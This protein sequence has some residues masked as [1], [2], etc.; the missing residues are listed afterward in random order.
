MTNCAFVMEQT[1]GHVTHHQNL[2]RWADQDASIRAVWLPV[3]ESEVDG[4]D[5]VPGIRSNWSLRGSLRAWTCL[6][7]AAKTQRL[8]AIFFHTQTVSLFALNWMARVPTVIS[9]DATPKNFDSF[10]PEYGH[11]AG[12]DSWLDRR[13]FR[14][15]QRTFESCAALTCMSDWAKRSLVEDYGIPPAKVTVIQP[16]VDLE[17]WNFAGERQGRQ[18]GRPLRLLFVGADFV[19]KGGPELVEA[20]RNG[21]QGTCQLDIVTKDAQAAQTLQGIEGLHVHLGLSPNSDPLRRLYANADLFVFPTHGECL[22][23]AAIE[24][25][26]AGL[27]VIATSVGGVPEVV[28]DGLNGLMIPLN[29]PS[30][31]G[32]AVRAL[33]ADPTRLENMACASREL[34]ER[35]FD[36]SRNYT[37]ILSLL[38]RVTEEHEG[39]K[40]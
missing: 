22:G 34:A 7:A 21:L 20:F 24:A 26:A 16:G 6:N 28:E 12:N 15:N 13:K 30:S 32:S 27:P 37:A 14:W 36:G 4:W 8:D 39:A 23:I 10:G 33:L 19:R 38:K 31:I 25:M 1:L 17:L 5:R 29:D 11:R 9:L 35:R 40:Q 18:D 2:A 3:S